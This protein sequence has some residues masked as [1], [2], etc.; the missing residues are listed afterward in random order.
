M[1]TCL[2]TNIYVVK[3]MHFI[4]FVILHRQYVNYTDFAIHINVISVKTMWIKYCKGA[5]TTSVD[6]KANFSLESQ[7]KN[8]WMRSWQQLNR[9]RR[10]ITFWLAFPVVILQKEDWVIKHAYQVKKAGSWN[11][12]ECADISFSLHCGQMLLMINTKTITSTMWRRQKV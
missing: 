1:L 4:E 11:L 3:Q 2:Q 6:R 9:N 12:I 7:E 8:G 5:L 10:K